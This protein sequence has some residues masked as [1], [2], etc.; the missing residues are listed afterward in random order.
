MSMKTTTTISHS[1]ILANAYMVQ[2]RVLRMAEQ[3]GINTT[4]IA[5]DAFVDEMIALAMP[6]L[7]DLGVN[8]VND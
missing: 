3:Q 4:W 1:K 6:R 8:I 5:T 7:V 2:W